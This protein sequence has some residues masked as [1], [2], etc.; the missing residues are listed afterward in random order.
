MTLNLQASANSYIGSTDVVLTGTFS[1][2]NN[3]LSIVLS[4]K[5][6]LSF[7][8]ARGKCFGTGTTGDL[9]L[10]TAPKGNIPDAS[11]AAFA[12]VCVHWVNTSTYPH[13]AILFRVVAVHQSASG[14]NNISLY[15]TGEDYDANNQVTKYLMVITRSGAKWSYTITTLQ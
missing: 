2:S 4:T 5:N 14:V 12:D 7:I 13:V 9:Y 6:L 3:V 8:S 10:I 11:N 1:I 15:L